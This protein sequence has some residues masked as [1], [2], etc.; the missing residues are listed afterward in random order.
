[1]IGRVFLARTWSADVAFDPVAHAT[2]DLTVFSAKFTQARQEAGIIEIECLYPAGGFL[3][4][5]RWGILSVEIDGVPVEVARGEIVGFP[6]ALAGQTVRVQMIC[7]R[8][9][10]V[11]EVD[12]LF[13]SRNAEVPVELED[14]D[15]ARRTEA[16]LL[17][18]IYHDPRTLIASLEPIAGNAPPVLTLCGEGAAPGQSQ[19]FALS[20]EITDAPSTKCVVECQVDFEQLIYGKFNAAAEL[21]ALPASERT[22]FTPNALADAAKNIAL[23]GGYEL[24][25]SSIETSPLLPLTV[26]TSARTV[27]PATCVVT[28]AARVNMMEHQIVDLHL[29][30]LAQAVQPRRERFRVSVAPLLLPFGGEAD[31][32]EI[33]YLTDAEKRAETVQVLSYEPRPGSLVQFFKRGVGA[34]I[35]TSGGAY[36][37]TVQD[38]VDALVRRAARTA[39]ERA[40]CVQL[41]IDT[42]AEVAIS[43][44]LKDRVRVTDARLPAGV[45]TGKIV[46]LEVEFGQSDRGRIV[47]ACPVSDSIDVHEAEI[48]YSSMSVLPGFSIDTTSNLEAV[49]NGSAPALVDSFSLIDAG[50]VQRAEIDGTTE[51]YVIAD[52]EDAVSKTGIML[53]LRDLSPSDVENLDEAVI[54]FA[55]VSLILPEGIRL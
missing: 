54:E 12:D 32:E 8:P 25:S 55:P 27:D 13:A 19:I 53:H 38:I 6:L 45:A 9:S 29:D 26:Y 20:A 44:T 10:H 36:R 34:S 35:F 11:E 33:V 16:Y 18:E 39:I 42:T 30:V 3:T 7:R 49:R 2:E 14:I 51:T 46:G 5:N 24:L 31:A 41:T 52:P 28:K 47:L 37:E 4:S 23:D 48:Q 15:I 21:S 1:M 22:T 43:L 17:D 50:D 40:H